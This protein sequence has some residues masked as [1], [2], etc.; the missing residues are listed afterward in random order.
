MK[1]YAANISNTAYDPA[2]G[3]RFN[4]RHLGYVIYYKSPHKNSH[5]DPKLHTPHTT[6]YSHKEQKSVESKQQAKQHVFLSL[7]LSH[8]FFVASSNSLM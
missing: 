8:S 6:Q 7:S 5:I 2:D 1:I 3:W 4:S